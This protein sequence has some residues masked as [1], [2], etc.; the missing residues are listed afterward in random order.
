MKSGVHTEGI[1]FYGLRQLMD[2]IWQVTK[3]V[4]LVYSDD[5]DERYGNGWYLQKYP[6]GVCSKL[7]K[8]D[9]EAIKDFKTG[10][11]VFPEKQFKY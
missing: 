5:D 1:N 7:F 3:D 4:D 2:C 11:V 6:G 8:T 10:N 9:M